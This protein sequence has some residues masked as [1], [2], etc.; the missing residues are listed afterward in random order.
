MKTDRTIHLTGRAF[1]G[2]S[3]LR[4]IRNV[5]SAGA[6]SMA[7]LAAVNPAQAKDSS[8]NSKTEPTSSATKKGVSKVTH[9]RSGSEESRAERDRRM[10][11][12]CKGLHNA[13]ACRG[14]TR[15]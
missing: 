12:E 14:Y 13:G 8:D 10:H 7:L 9:Q 5:L 6:V 4:V 15:K 2:T 1:T 11:R 3:S